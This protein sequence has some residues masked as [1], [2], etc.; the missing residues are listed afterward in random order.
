MFYFQLSQVIFIVVL[1]ILL[2]KKTKTQTQRRLSFD[3]GLKTP[4]AT[5]SEYFVCFS[6]VK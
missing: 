3:K 1:F 5:L 6:N 2:E 4:C